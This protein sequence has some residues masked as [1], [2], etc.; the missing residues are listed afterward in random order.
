MFALIFLFAFENYFYFSSASKEN[1][2]TGP[3]LV[4]GP[5]QTLLSA[6][7][8][9]YSKR[10][11]PQYFH[12]PLPLCLLFSQLPVSLPSGLLHPRVLQLMVPL[13]VPVP[14]G[15]RRCG[16]RWQPGVAV[17]LDELVVTSTHL[18]PSRSA[19][20]AL[21]WGVTVSVKFRQKM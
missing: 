1:S 17:T 7:I 9:H 18:Y 3:S 13:K 19:D 4:R 11:F 12:R 20:A 15:R 6:L 8:S 21:G 16:R 2:Q 10:A 5:L 14:R